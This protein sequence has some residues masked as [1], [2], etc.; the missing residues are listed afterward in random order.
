MRCGNSEGTAKGIL[1]DILEES[2]RIFLRN[3]T[4]VYPTEA[5]TAAK[6]NTSESNWRDKI[7][8]EDQ[9]E[10]WS[11]TQPSCYLDGVDMMVL[12]ARPLDKDLFSHKFKRADYRYQ[13]AVALGTS[14]IVYVGGGVPCGKWP[15]LKLVRQTLLK[16]IEPYEK[17]AAD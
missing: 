4:L 2:D 14:K 1:E 6:F 8:F 7:H 3:A 11:C 9:F 17:V 15:G 5:V 12:E 16:H 13:V 10:Q